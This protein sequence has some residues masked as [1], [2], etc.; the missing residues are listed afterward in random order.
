[1]P[2]IGV[3]TVEGQTAVTLINAFFPSSASARGATSILAGVTPANSRALTRYTKLDFEQVVGLN[4]DHPAV[5]GCELV[6]EKKL[7]NNSK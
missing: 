2:V 7:V 1:M 4:L 3:A 5:S 6:L